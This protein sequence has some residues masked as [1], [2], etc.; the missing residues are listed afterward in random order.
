VFR[1]RLTP[2]PGE[3]LHFAPDLSQ[4]HLFDAATGAVLRA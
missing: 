4:A 1:E 3:I 2:R